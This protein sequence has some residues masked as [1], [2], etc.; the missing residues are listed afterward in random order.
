MTGIDLR[1]PALAALGAVVL[2]CSVL[3]AGA[4]RTEDRIALAVRKP[5]LTTGVGN[6]E[7][8]WITGP[9]VVSYDYTVTCYTQDVTIPTDDCQAVESAGLVPLFVETGT[10]PRL[11]SE[12]AV[13]VTGLPTDSSTIDCF[14]NIDGG[15]ADKVS[16][17]MPV[18]QDPFRIALNGVTVTCL[19]AEVG[20]TGELNGIEYTKRDRDG[21]LALVGS[22][23]TEAELATSCTTGVSSMA[24]L[25]GYM[26]ERSGI[27]FDFGFNWYSDAADPAT[28]NPDISS[29]DMS[30][31][32]NMRAMLAGSLVFDRDVSAWDTA[33]VTDM[34]FVF[35]GA[36]NFDQSLDGYGWD[37]SSVTDT[38]GMFY[39]AQKFNQDLNHFDMAAV[40]NTSYMMSGAWLFNN[41]EDAGEST[42]PLNWDTSSLTETKFMFRGAEDFNQPVESLDMSSVKVAAGMF[43]A[44]SSFNQ[45]VE[46]WDM[47]QVERL[48]GMFAAAPLFNRPVNGWN[49]AA[50]TN[51]SWVFLGAELFD[52]PLDN[53]IT[54]N[55]L[56]MRGMFVAALAFNQSLSSWDTSNVQS[57]AGMFGGAIV[58]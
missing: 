45:P 48:D 18:P 5:S 58:R 11:Y 9:N 23:A 14:I 51:M 4:Q 22:E 41:G 7:V 29:W 15:P 57:F 28:F 32:T 30:S 8:T 2:A 20:D 49:T 33:Q 46:A 44:A 24:E 26:E 38:V 56:D 6:A 39:D 17:C 13:E 16:K 36:H 52:Q 47:S 55:C 53:W 43:A 27:E 21:L 3:A 54:T 37:M 1:K 25:F 35:A 34:S 31:V 10:L 19:D 12:M 42:N 40:T 50:V